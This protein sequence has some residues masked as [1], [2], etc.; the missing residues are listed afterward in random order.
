[1]GTSSSA[2]NGDNIRSI[3]Y[4]RRG[5][6]I[7]TEE[8][9][10]E[11]EKADDIGTTALFDNE[12][13][14]IAIGAIGNKNTGLDF[15][16]TRFSPSGNVQ[17]S[18]SISTRGN[19]NDI[20]VNAGIDTANNILIAGNS[21]GNNQASEAM[22]AKITQ[23]NTVEWVRILPAAGRPG[24]TVNDLTIADDGGP[25][26]AGAKL[27][28]PFGTDMINVKL[29]RTGNQVWDVR[30]SFVQGE[31]I[32]DAATAIDIDPQGDILMAGISNSQASG[33]GTALGRDTQLITIKQQISPPTQNTLPTVSITQPSPGA[34]YEFEQE[35]SIFVTANDF[36][37][38]VEKVEI[39]VGDK[40]IRTLR[41]APFNATWI[42]DTVDPIL[43]TARV[44][45]SDGAVVSAANPV[46]VIVTDIRPEIV[47]FP[48]D[49]IVA[50]G[51]TL[52]LAAEVTGRDPIRY[53]WS[54]NNKRLKDADGPILVI[55]NFR[56][57]DAGLYE[58]RV[59]NQAGR[60]RSQ[61]I[62]IEL[63]VPTVIAG[64][65][66][67]D[68]VSL[69]G[70]SG[71]VKVSN[72]GATRETGEPLHANKRSNHSVWFSY[73][74]GAQGLVEISTVGANFDTL[75]AVYTGT[76]L[77]NI[78]EITNDEDRGGFL[79]S[80]LQFKAE[81]DQEYIILVDGFNQHEGT[82]ILTWSLDRTRVVDVPRFSVQPAERVARP[83]SQ[84]V[85]NATLQGPRP[86]GIALQWFFNGEAIE[87]ETSPQLRVDSIDSSQVGRYWVEA[88]IGNVT[89]ISDHAVLTLAAR[90]AINALV[91]P[92]V[93][94]ENKFAD[95]FFSFAGANAQGL[96]QQR[97][98]PI[99]LAASLATG[100]SGAQIFNT[101]GA[102]KELG[103]PDHCDVP[104]GA[105]QWFAYQP[106]ADGVVGITT[107][108]SDF[109]TVIAVY[110]TA[111]S[112]FSS[113]T[114]VAC[115]N[116]SGVD[117]F[118]STVTFD[119]TANTIY[120]VAVDGVEAA[121]GVVELAYA[122]E[123]PLEMT[124]SIG[125]GLTY[126][127]GDTSNTVSQFVYSITAAPNV[128]FVV[129][130]SLDLETWSTVITAQAGPDGT[131]QFEDDQFSLENETRYFR[132][133]YP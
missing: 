97:R 26:I 38:P 84:V 103:E 30:F 47:S 42:V 111:S 43:I 109:D 119:A 50:P 15:N 48:S 41:T 45:D 40:V 56:A 12:N 61:P 99:R 133:F 115:D 116:D 62:S 108:G 113:L 6:E 34:R 23:R 131:Y 31:M 129:E 4:N 98:R 120:Y 10:T 75:L 121:T 68:R 29:D 44:T 22:L 11:G 130:S 110:T 106:P 5:T 57:E 123:L 3:F 105:S 94:I 89:A 76:T 96:Q 85:F 49:Q 27:N 17:F 125:G 80:S 25:V 81:A 102:V 58:L 70:E 124:L 64:D 93:K 36:E 35:I 37:G 32:Y 13:R 95:I 16:M 33:D 72:V 51:G 91:I 28:Q 77:G 24:D 18:R 74:A 88:T 112:D 71:Q 39:L 14:P 67:A 9:F 117:G 86:P 127:D 7:W 20:P 118:D 100:Y 53:V 2:D 107:D 52:T 8:G 114:E 82:A 73:V 63:D 87:N 128:D 132:V 92:E 21:L 78:V 60:D 55:E 83:G 59:E 101:F 104:G 1:M 66:F 69:A 90:R 79:T 122:M 19:V 65:N 54:K 46:E 126:V